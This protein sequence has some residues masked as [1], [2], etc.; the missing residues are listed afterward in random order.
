MSSAQKTLYER[1]GG[2]DAIAAV[3]ADLLGRLRGD[4]QL[5]RFWANRSTDS[6]KRELQLLTEFFCSKA[7]GPVYYL[8]HDVRTVHHGMQITES[9]WEI[10]LRNA[11]VTLKKFEVPETEQRELTAIAENFK[12][13]IVEGSASA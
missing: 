9:D 6:L 8:G 2:Y 13:D 4:P 5:G 7:G 3:L 10:F 1:L 12:K 11:A